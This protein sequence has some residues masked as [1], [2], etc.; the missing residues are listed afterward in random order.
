MRIG[1]DYSSPMVDHLAAARHARE[2]LW[3]LRGE[4]GMRKEAQQVFNK[5]GSRRRQTKKTLPDKNAAQ[6][7]AKVSAKASAQIPPQLSLLLD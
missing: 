5:H 1:A 3:A 6:V 4:Q 2:T 7:S